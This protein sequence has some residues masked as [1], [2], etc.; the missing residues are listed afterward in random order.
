MGLPIC[1]NGHLIFGVESY[2]LKNYCIQCKRES[3]QKWYFSTH[4]ERKKKSRE[5]YFDNREAEL[6]RQRKWRNENREKFN[7]QAKRFYHKNRDKILEKCKERILNP[8][9]SYVASNMGV[10]L[11][12]LPLE[13]L[14][15]RCQLLIVKRELKKWKE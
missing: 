3:N 10:K 11:G 4:Y 13:I 15:L 9:P 8:K 6:N 1:K 7:E 2:D 14:K 5:R 12:D